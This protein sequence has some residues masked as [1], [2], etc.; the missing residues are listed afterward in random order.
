MLKRAEIRGIRKLESSAVWKKN[1]QKLKKYINRRIND[2]IV[3]TFYS[4]F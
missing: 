1:K 4:F 2:D 3:S